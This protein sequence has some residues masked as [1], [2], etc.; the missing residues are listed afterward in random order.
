M[1]TIEVMTWG[2]RVAVIGRDP[3]SQRYVFEYYPDWVE[4]R[5]ELAPLMMPVAVAGP[6]GASRRWVFTDLGRGFRGLPGLAADALPDDFGNRLINAYMQSHGVK[7]EDATAIDR[8][9]Y[10]GKRSM[11]ALEFKPAAGPQRESHQAL[12]MAAL[13]EE[14]RQA[15]AGELS[16]DKVAAEAL[17]A[18]IRVGTSAGGAR[19][20]GVIAWNPKDDRIVSGQ[21][22]APA[23]FEHWLLKFDGV[24]K[25]GDDLGTP[26]GYGRIEY[27][28]SLMAQ[29]AGI[30]MMPCQL[31]EENGRAHFMTKRFDREG[32]KKHHVQTLCALCHLDYKE[33]RAFAYE[34]LFGTIESIIKDPA[35]QAYAKDQAFRRMAFNQMAANH[36]DHTK[37]FAFILRQGEG[38]K[39]APAYDVTYAYR[40]ES[41]WVSAHQLSVQGKF[42]GVTREDMVTVAKLFQ[43]PNARKILQEIAEA[44][45]AWHGFAGKAGVPQDR[46]LALAKQFSLVD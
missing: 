19:P 40:A 31:R 46:A 5:I 36:D 45:G 24:S 17:R 25:A 15:M 6:A 3:R 27:A 41:E 30:D 35:D 29:S 13:V 16:D 44:I 38:W 7:P 42:S 11:G 22:D 4:R 8:L 2:R 20:K 18:I 23:G 34:Q 10:M 26:V 28:Y 32:T 12:D 37:N 43:V 21:F 33:P 14:A 39:I 9:A 1:D